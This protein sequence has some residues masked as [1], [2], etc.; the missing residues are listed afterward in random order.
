MFRVLFKF[1]VLFSIYMLLYSFWA[2]D[3]LD[4]RTYEL[5]SCFEELQAKH[6]KLVEIVRYMEE[7]EKC[8]H[9]KMLVP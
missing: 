1:L 6:N 8:P 7:R 3:K 5:K 9:T 4:T 2:V